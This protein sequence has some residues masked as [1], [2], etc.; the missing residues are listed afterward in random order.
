MDVYGPNVASA[1]WHAWA[2]QRKVVA[3][4]FNEGINT[5]V[6]TESLSQARDML[7][8][9]TR[10]GRT[11]VPGVAMDTRMLSLDVL[12]ATGFR[13]SYKFRSSQ[14]PSVDEARDYRAALKIVLDNALLLMMLPPKLLA[15]PCMP[16]SVARLGLATE[17]LRK[18]MLDMLEGE[19]LLLEQGK[20]GT[21]S[22]MTS[23][24]RALKQHEKGATHSQGL[25]LCEILGN[26]FAINFAGHDTT[27][28]TLAFSMLLLA[29]HP[30][31]Q[32]WI[33]EEL[34][35]IVKDTDSE[36]WKYEELFPKLKRC[37]AVLVCATIHETGYMKANQDP[38]IGDPTALPADHVTPEMD[39]TETTTSQ[40][41]KPGSQRTS[42]DGCS[43][44]LASN[45]NPS[46]LLGSGPADLASLAMD[47]VI[48]S[49]DG[50]PN[51]SVERRRV[52]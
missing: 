25:S 29:S 8:S 9:W 37:R 43:D 27:A 22:L 16:K 24:V 51:C 30:K 6:W 48:T 42:R 19:K 2:R 39:K 4:P 26:M 1:D 44:E 35:E 23:F 45:P 5:F 15:L 46:I 18:Y 21:G 52:L 11:G 17:E 20:A 10:Y 36:A 7:R 3:A 31:V 14:D 13:R 40:S 50:Q 34:K 38:L 28:N 41:W 32:D 12:A 49:G 47:H 33:G